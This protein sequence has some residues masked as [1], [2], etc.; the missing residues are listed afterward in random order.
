MK[1]L[2]RVHNST[3]CGYFSDKANRLTSSLP[4]KSLPRGNPVWSRFVTHTADAWLFGKPWTII[5]ISKL[6]QKKTNTAL[7]GIKAESLSLSSLKSV[8]V[9]SLFVSLIQRFTALREGCG[10]GRKC[11]GQFKLKICYDDK[12]SD[13]CMFLLAYLSL[14]RPLLSHFHMLSYRKVFL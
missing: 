2:L 13:T 4:S 12:W 9:L 11:T 6:L 1:W 8:Q 5:S 10:R 3:D 14:Q 7:G